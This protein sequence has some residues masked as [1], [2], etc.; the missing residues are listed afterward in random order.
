MSLLFRGITKIR[1]ALLAGPFNN[2][3]IRPEV[4]VNAESAPLPNWRMM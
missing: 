2:D 4:Q 1:A 3:P